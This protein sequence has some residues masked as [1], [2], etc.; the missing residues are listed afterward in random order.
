MVKGD[1]KPPQSTWGLPYS[2]GR[3]L[4]I[5]VSRILNDSKKIPCVAGVQN[6]RVYAT[7]GE[8]GGD[9]I[10]RTHSALVR[11]KRVFKVTLYS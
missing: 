1:D 8:V 7:I 2:T 5:L 4:T 9:R 3:R 6:P 11:Q 10:S